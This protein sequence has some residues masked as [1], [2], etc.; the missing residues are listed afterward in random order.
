MAGSRRNL[1]RPPMLG[2]QG[3]GG[4]FNWIALDPRPQARTAN[5]RATH[6]RIGRAIP[7]WFCFRLSV[8]AGAPWSAGAGEESARPRL[9][10]M[11]VAHRRILACARND[12]VEVAGLSN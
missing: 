8:A 12:K 6:L 4:F 1:A 2:W 3:L 9:G 7:Q 10:A 5:R 11:G